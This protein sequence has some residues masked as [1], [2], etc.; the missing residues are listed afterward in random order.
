MLNLLKHQQPLVV[1]IV[2]VSLV[3]FTSFVV[4]RFT[5]RISSHVRRAALDIG[6]AEHKVVVGVVENGTVR[7][8]LYSEAVGVALGEDLRRQNGDGGLSPPALHSSAATLEK[9]AE[10]ASRYGARASGAATAV[11]RRSSNGEE[12]I[13]TVSRRFA[14]NISVI[15]QSLEGELGYATALA[16]FKRT[17]PT[18]NEIVSW[19]S[20]GG[21]FQFSSSGRVFEGPIGSADVSAAYRKNPKDLLRTVDEMLPAPPQWLRRDLSSSLKVVAFGARSSLFRLAADLAGNPTIRRHDVVESFLDLSR[22]RRDETGAG[23]RDLSKS[24]QSRANSVA[25]IVAPHDK[26]APLKD[27]YPEIHLVLP[28]LALLAAVMTKFDLDTIHYEYAN[29]NCLGV[30]VHPAFW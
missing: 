15:P 6:S 30:L 28:K 20:G 14:L 19:D 3:V 24:L 22:D 9:F 18:A 10:I 17:D 27:G 25:S 12:Y 23:E 7:E 8:I 21:S 16:A 2:S 13:E 11:F 29:G 26:N 4:D 5:R 1:V